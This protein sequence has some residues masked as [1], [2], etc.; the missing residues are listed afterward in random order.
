MKRIFSMI[1]SALLLIGC[2][3]YEDIT[4]DETVGT[5]GINGFLYSQCDTNK[6][7][8]TLTGI[9][10]PAPVKNATVEL[11]VNGNLCETKTASD[12]LQGKYYGLKTIFN[13]GDHIRVDVYYGNQHAYAEDVCPA[14][15]KDL[16]AAVEFEENY[17]YRDAYDE[18]EI[19]DLYKVTMSFADADGS[20]ENYYRV[21]LDKHYGYEGI[22]EKVESKT[23]NVEYEDNPEFNYSYTKD[24]VYYCH[25]IKHLHR[26][27]IADIANYIT[28]YENNPELRPE[29]RIYDSYF[30]DDVCNYFRIFK[31][32]SF[33]GGRC[34]M[35]FHEDVNFADY[36]HI[37][38]YDKNGRKVRYWHDEK[39]P[40]PPSE[41]KY[42]TD[43]ELN[44]IPT[45]FYYETVSVE[46]Y[47]AQ[48][49]ELLQTLNS[50]ISGQYSISELTGSVKM[51]SN[52]SGGTGYIAAVSRITKVVKVIDGYQPEPIKE[53]EEEE[54]Y[55]DF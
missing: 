32:T 17:A 18:F 55:E 25:G 44:D 16:D 35:T 33:A 51:Y 54:D 48:G 36:N 12:S 1:F 7:L 46:S 22:V 40:T 31:N 23:V 19:D 43:E 24:T 10:S 45:Y 15:P 38:D 47:S 52:V 50:Y 34:T 6:V 27:G 39:Y 30:W 14:A 53:E 3:T 11:R 42:S 49:Y 29:E 13:P 4:L 28:T 37:R 2:N 8:V 41:F 5:L 21:S 20:K 9:G 26:S